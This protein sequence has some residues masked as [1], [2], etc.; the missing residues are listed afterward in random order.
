MAI[1][2]K[3][4][5][6]SRG[7]QA[8]RRPAAA[9]RAIAAGRRRTAWY[10]TPQG[11]AALIV[12]LLVVAGVVTGLVLKAKS[13]STKLA[14]R[15]NAI[16]RYTGSVRS[17]LQTIT[18][19]ASEMVAAPTDPDDA[20]ALDDL[21]KQ[22]KSWVDT[23][24]TATKDVS[25]LRP[26]P[27]AL[28]AQTIFNQSVVVYRMAAQQYGL[29]PDANDKIRADL[30]IAAAGLRDEANSLWTNATTIL[31]EARQELELSASGLR[32]PGTAPPGGQTTT[33]PTP[34]DSSKNSVGSK[35]KGSKNG[36]K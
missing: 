24:D 21:K 6:Q 15:Q 5:S 20:A 35:K 34:L 32:S 28:D 30:L 12:A 8:R 11:R 16:E 10:K 2:G 31:D 18:P 33:A 1:K 14:D 19:A 13:N 27:A 17:V 9:P 4:K 3:K 25:V 23:L 36:S 29:V 26:P 22:S 7:S